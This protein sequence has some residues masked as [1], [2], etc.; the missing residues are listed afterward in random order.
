MNSNGGNVQ[1][2]VDA[3]ADQPETGTVLLEGPMSGQTILTPSAPIATDTII[4]WFNDLP[5][6]AE[7][8]FRIDLAEIYVR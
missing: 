5:I 8:K 2:R 3:S 4:L 6:D 7:G 1:W